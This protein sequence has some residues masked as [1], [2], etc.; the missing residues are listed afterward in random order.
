MTGQDSEADCAGICPIPELHPRFAK[1][2]VS[3]AQT[4]RSLPRE[5]P[6]ACSRSRRDK[7]PAHCPLGGQ[8]SRTG[9]GGRCGTWCPG[10]GQT[11][12]RAAS[13]LRGAAS[14][15]HALELYLAST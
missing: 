12:A 15:R 11:A 4:P 1:P 8:R 2:E 10:W 7:P 14:A 3:L 13:V 5:A 9:W 6:V